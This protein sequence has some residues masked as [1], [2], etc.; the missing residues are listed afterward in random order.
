MAEGKGSGADDGQ[1]PRTVSHFA[2]ETEIPAEP[3]RVVVTATGQLDAAVTLGT[4]PVGATA[5]DGSGLVPDYLPERLPELADDIK[6]IKP[7]GKR[8]EPNIEAIGAL[9][10]DLILMN[11]RSDDAEKTYAALSK[12]APTV[13]SQGTGLNWK[14]DYLL[15]A[16][17]LGKTGEAEEWLNNFEA[18]AAEFG[19][20]VDPSATFSF[21]RLNG[22]RLRIFQVSSF[23]G[24]VAEDIG[25]ARPESQQGTE[26]LSLDISPEE[27][28]LADATWV[29]YGVQGGKAPELTDMPLW[30][31]LEA[32]ATEQAVQVDDDPFYL[33]AGPTA[34]NVV[35]DQL[36]QSLGA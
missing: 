4:V 32:V 33:N 1:F 3:Q 9:K 10:P 12:I 28:D 20:T 6:A 8:G 2:G 34:A 15:M 11:A 7:V 26:D 30:P 17:A 29:F 25:L 18:D 36:K 19:E 14:P 24:A 27:L 31:T 5:G 13:S 35:V 21:L 16:D 23:P 22:D